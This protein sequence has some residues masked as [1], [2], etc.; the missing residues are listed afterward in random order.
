MIITTNNQEREIVY[1]YDLAKEEKKEFDYLEGDDLEYG[2]F[3]RYKGRVF[4]I[5]EFMRAPKDGELS[6]W[7]GYSADSYFSGT[8]IK[9]C[10]GGESVIVGTYFI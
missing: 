2:Q 1:G 5:G 8:V 7:H 6:A 9:I 4:D 3:F 10:D